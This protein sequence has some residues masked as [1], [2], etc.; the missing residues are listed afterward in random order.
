MFST[1]SKLIMSYNG[2]KDCT[3]LLD[4]VWKV[5]KRFPVFSEMKLKT[6]YVA[7][8]DPFPDLENF[9]SDTLKR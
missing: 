4:M 8:N 2:G 1:P 3:V 9:I 7:E 5:W 6:V